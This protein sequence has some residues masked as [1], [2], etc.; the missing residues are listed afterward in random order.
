MTKGMRIESKLQGSIHIISLILIILLFSACAKKETLKPQDLKTQIKEQQPSIPFATTQDQSNQWYKE[1]F[2]KILPKS[3]NKKDAQ[4]YEQFAKLYF[5]DLSQLQPTSKHIP[6]D[7]LL[8]SVSFTNF[9]Q[10]VLLEFAFLQNQGLA[11]APW[12]AFQSNIILYN[13]VLSASFV[14]NV[15]AEINQFENE[16]YGNFN[17]IVLAYNLLTLT[18]KYTNQAVTSQTTQKITGITSYML[19]DSLYSF[20]LYRILYA[21]Y[22]EKFQSSYLLNLMA[23]QFPDSTLKASNKILYTQVKYNDV[24][25][26]QKYFSFTPFEPTNPI[27]IAQCRA[28]NTLYPEQTLCI[29]T[30]FIAWLIYLQST[31][32][33]HNTNYVLPVFTDTKLCLLIAKDRIIPYPNNNGNFCK[34]LI[35]SWQSYKRTKN[36]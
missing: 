4:D 19:P 2:T 1:H 27:S 20:L 8:Q 24:K 12:E 25:T 33:R 13:S 28:G 5:A 3:L 21:K 30:T 31:L 32:I 15:A 29:Q 26:M 10:E 16:S 22:A 35:E 11:I 9:A 36:Y 23:K 17:A 34:N 7:K 14:A 6:K 18:K